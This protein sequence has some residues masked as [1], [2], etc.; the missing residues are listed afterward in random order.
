MIKIVAKGKLKTGVREEYLAL[1]RELAEET[2]KEPGCLYYAV[3][4]EINDSS[5]LTMLEEWKDEEAV[6]AHGESAHV[7]RIVPELRKLR[8][9]VEVNQYREIQ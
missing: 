6:K 2:R 8:E 3:H 7:N 4:E 1:A 9:W 5:I